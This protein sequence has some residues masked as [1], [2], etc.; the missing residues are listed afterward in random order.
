[1]PRIFRA[2]AS[3]ATALLLTCGV[4]SAQ[5]N[6]EKDVNDTID[7]YLAYAIGAGHLNAGNAASGLPLLALLEKNALPAGYN[8]ASDM[9]KCLARNAVSQIIKSGAHVARGFFA[10]Y[11]DGIDMMALS[12]YQR[13]GGP[14]PNNVDD[15]CAV[16]TTFT[17]GVTLSVTT[18]LNTLVDRAVASQSV[19]GVTSGFWG[20]NGPG[21]DSSTT[22]FVT[23]GLAAAKGFY[24][25]FG[26]PG[27]RIPAI[28]S[29]TSRT[30]TGYFNNIAT[31]ASQGGGT[32]GG[33]KYRPPSGIWCALI[34]YQQTASGLW[35]AGLGGA[36]INDTQVQEAFLW[37]QKH[38]N[39]ST[40]A[41]APDCWGTSYGYFL[42]SSSK[43][44]RL[45]DLQV[46]NA[47]NLK[48]SALGTLAADA[49]QG[50]QAQRNPVGDPCARV[51]FPAL[52][53]GAYNDFPKGWY[54]DYA[55]T[56]MSRQV[57]GGSY[58]EPSGSWD[59]V[60]NQAYYTLV[61]ERSLAGACI[62]NDND[63]VC[64][65]IDNCP[66]ISN[67]NQ[68]DTDKDGKGDVCDVDNK[69]KLNVGTSPGYGT[70]GVTNISV[71]GGPWPAGATAND[72]TVNIA[73]TCKGASPTTVKAA[74]LV[75]II[76]TTKRATFKIPAGLAT[77]MYKVWVSGPGIDTQNCSNM[78]VYA[79][80]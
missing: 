31:Q 55:Y 73:L 71:I 7:A 68:Q 29:A 53:H 56:I 50:R 59:T 54:Y 39:Y 9:H 77:N 80:P 19:A 69:I 66:T 35:A 49:T 26:D 44:Y 11:V 18:A 21:D 57:A 16:N 72:V 58:S 74:S 41:Y 12:F 25:D 30:K 5:T 61:L 27:N 62:D 46:A 23:G 2:F 76:G 47:G 28:D 60:S 63:G 17:P 15:P 3:V 10:A 6:F 14:N 32:E 24:L 34:S 75:T 42:F 65:D 67:A 22:Q 52:C 51:A 13:T 33:W 8:G 70:S 78:Q 64:D 38:Y 1:M 79:A 20:Y 36:S 40:I 37:Q 43:A 4:A 45:Y 48:S